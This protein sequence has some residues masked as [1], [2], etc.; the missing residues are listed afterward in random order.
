MKEKKLDFINENRIELDF[1]AADRESAIR[2]AGRLLFADGLVEAHYIDA[3]VEVC[4]E[5]GPYIVL[6]P[7]IALPHARPADGAKRAGCSFLRLSEAVEFGHSKND[8]VRIVIALSAVN[9]EAHLVM[10]KTILKIA[11]DNGLAEALVK[12]EEKEAVLKL[13][14]SDLVSM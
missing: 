4:N 6:A 1:Y 3:M 13:L 12:A 2:E 9:S 10:L 7:G 11:S 8:P 14:R 5:Y